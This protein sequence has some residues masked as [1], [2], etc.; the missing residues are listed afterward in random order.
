MFIEVLSNNSVQRLMGILKSRY[1][2]GF[3]MGFLSDVTGLQHDRQQSPSTIEGDLLIPLWKNGH[4]L[5]TVKIPHGGLVAEKQ[6]REIIELVVMVLEPA[7]YL[8]I[9]GQTGGL[10]LG[11]SSSSAVRV[12]DKLGG[13]SMDLQD[14]SFDFTSEF[15][16][17][18]SSDKSTLCSAGFLLEATNP[19]LIPKVAVHIHEVSQRWAMLRFE[20]VRDTLN[21]LSDLKNLGAMTLLIQDVL[22]LNPVQQGLLAEYFEEAN[23]DTEPLVLIG[24]VGKL[25]DLV[26]KK[27]VHSVLAQQLQAYRLELDR[28]P[29][30][31]S[32]MKEALELV[33]DRRS[34]LN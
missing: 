7:L 23:V 18:G 30:D 19:H 10:T 11:D 27:S 33:L 26:T 8:T 22:S 20:D 6:R 9:L 32:Q 4:Y 29:R 31:F 5:G 1:G 21:S 34:L 13:I 24:C 15:S 25:T 12:S 14:L 17:S 28:M 3:E 16:D 2:L